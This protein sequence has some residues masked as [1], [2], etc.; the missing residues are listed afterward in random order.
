M[1]HRPSIARSLGV[2]GSFGFGFHG[3]GIPGI[4][5]PG[6]EP[7]GGNILGIILTNEVV[8]GGA[9]HS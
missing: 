4:G 3:F 1:T 8:M 5:L 2:S 9:A 6:E 7:L